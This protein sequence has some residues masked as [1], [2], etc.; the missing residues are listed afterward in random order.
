MAVHRRR[1]L[2]GSAVSVAGAGTAVALGRLPGSGTAGPVGAQGPSTVFAHGVASGDPAADRLVIW[3]RVTPTPD[4]QPGSGRGP[5]TAVAWQV[6]LTPD[7]AAPIAIGELTARAS[8][9]HTASV[10]VPGL[11]PDTVHWYRFTAAGVSSPVGRGRTA[12]AGDALVDRL[13]FGVV[14]CANWAGGRFSAYRRLAERDDVDWVLHL[15][16]YIYEYGPGEYGD[17]RDPDPPREMV[18]LADVRRRH[19][20][21]KTDPD[22]ALL[23]A[24][25]AFVCTWDDHEITNDTWRDGAE[26]HQPD[27]G[28]WAVRAAAARRAWFEWMPVRRPEA[29]TT[30]LHRE[31]RFGPLA[32]LQ[33]LDLRQYRDQQASSPADTATITDPDRTMLGSDQRSWFLDGIAASD[34]TWNL[35]AN[36]V[37]LTPI[38]FLGVTDL[39][40]TPTDVDA[41]VAPLANEAITGITGGAIPAGGVPYNVDQWD[42]YAAE[43]QAVLTALADA[44]VGGCISLVGDIHSSWA[45]ELRTEDARPVGVELVCTSVTSDNVDEIV[46]EALAGTPL[47]PGAPA[48][49]EVA[50]AAAI[51]AETVIDGANDDVR[52][53]ELRGHGYSV[54]E[55]TPEA[56]QMDWFFV[57]DRTEANS[58][59]SWYRS[60]RTPAGSSTLEEVGAPLA[61]DAGR[62]SAGCEVSPPPPATTTPSSTTTGDTSTTTTEPSTSTSTSGST[63]T[64]STSTDPAP[65]SSTG[66]H[67]SGGPTSGSAPGAID[68][69]PSSGPER[70][71]SAPSGVGSGG[72]GGT[73]RGPAGTVGATGSGALA[74]TGLETG[75]LLGTSAALLTAGTAA[76][77]AS[78]RL[79]RRTESGSPD[80]PPSP[81]GAA[82][83]PETR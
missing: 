2:V 61:V 23:H 54:L 51:A 25:V 70:S 1:F 81:D 21:Y 55:I 33:V 41:V 7:L 4:A 83:F 36:S 10:D 75:P 30:R 50:V 20:Q 34:A 32:R 26:N 17:E 35:V 58:P 5:D 43:Q 76:V 71:T 82:P 62:P 11:C 59:S 73:G 24:R 57:R 52:M 29:D 46:L 44:G 64:T 40:G 69:S 65:T 22:L 66:G 68:P 47:P 77:A 27:E 3:T 67:T 13:R 38:T 72:A 45:C 49:G 8:S 6:G 12:P 80:D 48:V 63:S 37:M 18:S 19:A 74:R 31:L 42:G 79:R 28:E 78:V 60:W 15:G 9:D 16:D 53:V 39:P 56:A 14:S